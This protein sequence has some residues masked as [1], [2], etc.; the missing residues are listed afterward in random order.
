MSFCDSVPKTW[1]LL[2]PDR[3][4]AVLPMVYIQEE[5]LEVGV[6]RIVM[7]IEGSNNISMRLKQWI[8]DSPG[9]WFCLITTP[10]QGPGTRW[11][12]LIAIP[13]HAQ[14]WSLHAIEPELHN[15]LAELPGTGQETLS[16]L[17]HYKSLAAR[18]DM[19]LYI[20]TLITAD[21]FQLLPELALLLHR[22]DVKGWLWD[23]PVGQ[24]LLLV[25]ETQQR[26]FNS[27]APHAIASGPAVLL[28]HDSCGK[29][30][31][32]IF[33]EDSRSLAASSLGFYP[34]NAECVVH[35]HILTID[36]KNSC[37]LT[38][39]LSQDKSLAV[40]FTP[41]RDCVT[42]KWNEVAFS[43]KR[44]ALCKM[45]S[46]HCTTCQPFARRLH[47][48]WTQCYTKT[49]S[50]AVPN[51][52]YSMTPISGGG[53]ILDWICTA[54]CAH[55]L[56]ACDSYSSL[57]I[58]DDTLNAM[59]K[60]ISPYLVGPRG[61]H[62]SGGEPFLDLPRLQRS[63]IAFQNAGIRIEFVETNGFWAK[64][65][66]HARH[67]LSKLR[68]MGLERLRLSISPFHEPF[69]PLRI[70]R[71]AY[72][73]ACAVLGQENVY[74]FDKSLLDVPPYSRVAFD[75]CSG[76]RAGYLGRSVG[77]PHRPAST[78]SKPCGGSLFGSGHAHFDG[79]G[80]IIPGVCT[81]IRLGNYNDLECLVRTINLSQYPVLKHLAV[82][83]PAALW[84]YAASQ[85]GIRE[86]STGFVGQCHC[87]LEVRREL[88]RL[89]QYEE[90]GPF[91]FYHALDRISKV[92]LTSLRWDEKSSRFD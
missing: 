1:F 2:V 49:T 67:I 59:L 24:P 17:E 3:E 64:D 10:G 53:I 92:D 73:V 74:I 83:G 65:I 11:Q 47:Q 70:V 85:H 29:P 20:R 8:E 66:T 87:C 91:V 7:L 50:R 75:L 13:A 15:R 35:E 39:P 34:A 45:S 19:S 57:P 30:D 81:G 71:N 48:D 9:T 79:E 43:N 44:S 38:C 56:F 23:L 72:T 55:C 37:L 68:E 6:K 61:L 77:L 14:V 89:D 21:N 76:G 5:A 42:R 16:S 69:I 26:Q 41:G 4:D 40:S 58:E 27:I 84:R 32:H 62:I 12:D 63:I 54:K 18:N 33:G 22:N 36:V 28:P 60:A 86:Q 31:Y 88:F 46:I 80:N 52:A 51:N 78:Y 82:G 90:L 25:S